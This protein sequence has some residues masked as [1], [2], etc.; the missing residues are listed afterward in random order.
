M[1]VVRIA[2]S[3]ITDW[4]SFHDVFSRALGF[5]A[6]Y[7]R[8]MDAWIDCLT[9]VDAP[10]D[11]MTRVM[12]GEGDVLTLQLDDVGPFAMRC[13][14]QYA[15]VLEGSAFVNWRRIEVGERPVIALSF[16]KR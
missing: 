16:F 2:C 11:G 4:Q 12:V 5:P 14:E 8:N 7:G 9:S 15:A 1:P 13:P 3:Q 10:E 6:F